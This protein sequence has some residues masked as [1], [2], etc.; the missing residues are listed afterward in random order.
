[1]ATLAFIS[2]GEVRLPLKEVT[3][4]TTPRSSYVCS[5]FGVVREGT[6]LEGWRGKKVIHLNSRSWERTLAE[7]DLRGLGPQFQGRLSYCPLLGQKGNSCRN[8]KSRE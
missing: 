2:M 5:Q 1:M 7:S 6:G 3:F 8:G 4:I